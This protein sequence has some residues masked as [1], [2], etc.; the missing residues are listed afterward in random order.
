MAGSDEITLTINNWDS[1]QPRKELKE[2]TWFRV[3]TGIFD[4][5]TYFKLKNDG[6]VLFLFL[7]TRAA[8]KNNPTLEISLD[9]ISEKLKLKNSEIESLLEKLVKNQLVLKSAQTCADSCLTDIQTNITNNTDKQDTTELDEVV[10]VFDFWNS[11]DLLPKALKL[12]S[13]RRVKIKLRL[14]ESG[15]ETIKSAIV[16]ITQTPFLL[17]QNDRNW[18][19]DL[20]W[21][22]ANETNLVKVTEGKYSNQSS[23]GKPTQAQNPFDVAKA[24]IDAINR[25]EL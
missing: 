18:K 3:E 14:K 19:A 13:A 15:L 1:F 20:D 5:Q 6:L 2:L 10:L 12:T 21:L 8:K 22:V 17:G 9:Y 16:T 7:I 23:K 11:Q 25:G 24:Q 4:G